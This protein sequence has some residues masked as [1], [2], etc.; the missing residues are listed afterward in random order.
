MGRHR[1]ETF[2]EQKMLASRVEKEDY[3][4]FEQVAK[5][6]GKSLQELVNSFI[7]SCIS[8][9]IVLD[10]ASNKFVVGDKKENV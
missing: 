4:K 2:H 3:I 10:S 5:Q 8:G 9:S 1:K 6:T 7:I